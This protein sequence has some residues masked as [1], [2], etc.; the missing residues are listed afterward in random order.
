MIS[1]TPLLVTYLS[2]YVISSLADLAIDFINS[3]QLKIRGDTVPEV[4][5]EVI[6]EEK[7]AKIN[8]Y[9]IDNTKIS[10]VR[11]VV[12][13]L[14]F[15]SIILSGFLP[16]VVSFLKDFHVIPAGLIFFAIPGLIAALVDLPFDYIHIF[17]IEEKYG[18]NTRTLK[19]WLS[20]ILKSLIITVILG[21]ILLSLLLA[22]IRYGGTFWWLWAWL[23]FFLFQLLMSALYP[24]VIAPIF[25]RFTPI[26]NQELAEKIKDLSNK[27]GLSIKGIFQMDAAR[28]SR[29][30]NAYFSGLSKTK[31][32]VLYD[33]LL[34]SHDDEEILAILAHEMG[35][36]RHRHILKQLA[37]MSVA[38]FILFFVASH[39][40]SWDFIYH[41]FGFSVMPIYVGI[42]IISA[43][44]EPLEF[45]ISPLAMSISR[46]F[47]R[48]A[49]QH[50][51]MLL[52]TSEPFIN[53]LKKMAS[54]NL[55]NL[56]PHPL[57]VRFNYSHPPLLERIRDH[58]NLVNQ[59]S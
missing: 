41:S 43:L 28:R 44:W 7:L 52:K 36:L 15:L 50:V 8:H 5:K 32:I 31:R 42:F 40:I 3:R 9:T 19:T 54:D 2:I 39:M 59:S 27:E 48:Q 49:D 6:D 21:G 29:H 23:V 55:A 26:Q 16:F 34:E 45:F 4:F 24:T 20:D 53:A 58:K 13:K 56:Y 47:E 14:L 30:T 33:T 25:N 51:F 37:I 11:S 57:Y 12:G 17:K 46:R 35:H 10:V 18:F 38:S 22:I 1:F